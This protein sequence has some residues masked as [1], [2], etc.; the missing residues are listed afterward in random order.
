[1][2]LTNKGTFGKDLLVFAKAKRRTWPRRSS[3]RSPPGRGEFSFGSCAEVFF[4][5]FWGGRGGRSLKICLLFFSG[6]VFCH[7]KLCFVWWSYDD[8]IGITFMLFCVCLYLCFFLFVLQRHG[9]VYFVFCCT[10][11]YILFEII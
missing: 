11:L 7:F 9:F 10:M 3:G 5:D 2:G 8:V 6:Y 1:M 4:F